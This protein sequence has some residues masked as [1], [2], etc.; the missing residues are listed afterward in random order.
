MNNFIASLTSTV[1]RFGMIL[2]A[3][4]LSATLLL[5]PAH[6]DELKDISQMA[7]QGQSAAAI[8]RVNT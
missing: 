6:A 1:T 2:P 5:S 4:I 3:G 8:D 7:D